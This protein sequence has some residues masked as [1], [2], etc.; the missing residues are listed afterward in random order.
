MTPPPLCLG[1]AVRFKLTLLRDKEEIRTCWPAT[2]VKQIDLEIKK[3]I[4]ICCFSAGM[5][6]VAGSGDEKQ[7]PEIISWK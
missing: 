2:S 4:Y 1:G 3:K 6:T 5:E 7:S